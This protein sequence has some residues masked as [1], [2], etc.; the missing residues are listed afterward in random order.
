M[1]PV[2]T[3]PEAWLLEVYGDLESAKKCIRL[4]R[5]DLAAFHFAGAAVTCNAIA[6]TLKGG[7][8]SDENMSIQD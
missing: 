4:N 1:K 7:K 3:F 5:T 8:Q 6:K 2:K